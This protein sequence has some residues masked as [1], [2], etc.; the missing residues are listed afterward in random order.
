MAP[1]EGLALEAPAEAVRRPQQA[2]HADAVIDRIAARVA[3]DDDL[4]AGLQRVARDALARQRAG[5][6][7]FDAPAL[8]LPFFV[9]RH[10][11][12]P[13]VR[14][15]EHELHE[16]AFDLDRLALVI[17]RRER[18]VRRGNRARQQDARGGDGDQ[19]PLHD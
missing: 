19:L 14:I 6:A 2:A 7:P 12:Y 17:R 8:H 1:V 18:M 15:A 3:R 11:V 5:S 16:L 9:R 13:R 4:V 10:H